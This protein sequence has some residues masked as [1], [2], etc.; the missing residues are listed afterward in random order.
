[1][2]GEQATMHSLNFYVKKS[3]KT[4]ITVHKNLEFFNLRRKNM[5]TKKFCIK[6]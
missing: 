3:A 4:S 1:M 2:R 6:D 5:K